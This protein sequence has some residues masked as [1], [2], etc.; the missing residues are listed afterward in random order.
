MN[1]K[2]LSCNLELKITFVFQHV[3][4]L[5]F[6]RLILQ[7]DNR[8]IFSAVDLI[9]VSI[10]KR[11]CSFKVLLASAE[12]ICSWLGF[13]FV[14]CCDVTCLLKRH[15]GVAADNGCVVF[16][17]LFLPLKSSLSVKI[18]TKR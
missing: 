7:I 5:F 18:K 8:W 12:L 3:F 1:A 13:A 17:C 2:V 16:C 10:V 11:V 14:T 15:E 6:F 9:L 4:K